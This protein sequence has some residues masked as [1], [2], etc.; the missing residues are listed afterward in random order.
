MGEISKLDSKIET[1][2]KL[3]TKKLNQ[4]K[5]TGKD[6]KL[7]KSQSKCHMKMTVIVY[8]LA[9]KSQTIKLRVTKATFKRLLPVMNY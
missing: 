6:T 1:L 2:V 8:M 4:Q 7:L 5:M 9:E 3:E